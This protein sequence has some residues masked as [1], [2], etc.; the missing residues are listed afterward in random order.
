MVPFVIAEAGV[1]VNVIFVAV[2]SFWDAG[3]T[4]KFVRLAAF[5]LEKKRKQILKLRI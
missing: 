2:D 3:V 1:N 5:N 4:V